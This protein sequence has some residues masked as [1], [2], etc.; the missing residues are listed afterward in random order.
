MKWSDVQTAEKKPLK[1]TPSTATCVELHSA[2]TAGQPDY[3]PRVLNF[4]K[5]K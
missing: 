5:Q 3:V 4:G 1:N 2:K